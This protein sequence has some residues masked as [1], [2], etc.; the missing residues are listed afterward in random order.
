MVNGIIEYD[1]DEDDSNEEDGMV[2]CSLESWGGSRLG[3]VEL[4][5]SMLFSLD[6]S[7][8]NLSYYYYY[9]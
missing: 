3:F 1:R 5:G 8:S 2:V 7:F 6:S 9:R 4:I